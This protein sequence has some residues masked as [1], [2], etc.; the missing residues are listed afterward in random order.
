MF[1]VG[2]RVYINELDLLVTIVDRYRTTDGEVMYETSHIIKDINGELE[3]SRLKAIESWFRQE[4]G[5][6]KTFEDIKSLYEPKKE[7]EVEPEEYNLEVEEKP[8]E[9]TWFGWLDFFKKD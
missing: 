7:P 8:K 1:E 9:K 3:S 6:Y 4:Y 2:E 5:D